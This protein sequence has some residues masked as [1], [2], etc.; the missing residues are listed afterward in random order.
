MFLHFVGLALALGT[1]FASFTLSKVATALAPEE[2]AQLMQRIMPLRKNGSYGLALLLLS[3]FGMFFLRGPANVMVWGGPAL[4]A[5]LTLVA[6]LCG[7]FGYAQ[8]VAKKLREVGG[9]A[10]AAKAVKLGQVMLI[11]SLAI[12]VCAVLAF[13]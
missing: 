8:V 1:G 9:A 12:V 3:G 5:K 4:H 13:K 2:R 11:L 10:L 6:I 7:V